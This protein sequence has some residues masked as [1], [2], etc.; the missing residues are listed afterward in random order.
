MQYTNLGKSGLVVSRLGLGMMSYGDTSRRQ[1][2]LDYAGA[3]PIVRC[4]ADGGITLFDT[5]DMYD[6]GASEIVTGRLLSA[7]FPNREDYVLA[8]KLYYPMSDSPNGRGLSRKHIFA[9]VDDSLRRL[10]SDY[11]DLYQIHRWDSLTPIEETMDALHDVV[12]SGKV[13]YLGASSMFAWHFATAQYTAKLAG[14]TQFI[15]MQNLYNL[16]YREEEREMIP[17]CHAT[18]VGILP[19]SP[20]ARGLLA[21]SSEPDGLN[22]VRG[23]ND[24]LAEKHHN[25]NDADVVNALRMIASARGLQPSQIA[26]AWLLAKDTV[27]APIIGATNIG[28]M[29]S[30]LAATDI[31]L[32][33]GEIEQLEQPYQP[34]PIVEPD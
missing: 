31:T 2:H 9:A 8:T 28:H 18:G 20:L 27:T 29:N 12:K 26:L 34:H 22:T 14:T 25:A 30:A 1:W 7:I 33:D 6:L 21:R 5:A 15:S 32:S 3:E 17:F 4:A 19:Y 10:N 13:R 24:P 16:A 11:I 23:K